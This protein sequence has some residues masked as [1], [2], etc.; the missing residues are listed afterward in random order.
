MPLA[1]QPVSTL[2][3]FRQLRLTFSS[4][5]MGT[6]LIMLL[7]LGAFH[8]N[9]LEPFSSQHGEQDV[10]N[11]SKLWLQ[12][13]LRDLPHITSIS[14]K[15]Q[16]PV[17]PLGDVIN[18]SRRDQGYVWAV[19]GVHRGGALGRAPPPFGQKNGKFCLKITNFNNKIGKISLNL[20]QSGLNSM[21]KL[22]LGG[23]KYLKSPKKISRLRRAPPF[24]NF[25][26][27]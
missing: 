5:S 27:R 13:F 23:V 24:W 17:S 6:L 19:T 16:F 9:R 11:L 4:N 12:Q 18:L 2:A 14:T 10:L 21:R 3:S 22:V 7:L 25:Y 1:S 20:I 8:L 26:A 15:R